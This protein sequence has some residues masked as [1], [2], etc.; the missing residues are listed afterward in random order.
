MKFATHEEFL[1]YNNRDDV[2][3][4]YKRRQMMFVIFLLLFPCTIGG[5]LGFFGMLNEGTPFF[6]NIN[7]Y[8]GSL[9]LSAIGFYGT[10]RCM[11]VIKRT[12]REDEAAAYSR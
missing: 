5:P 6:S 11:K 1:R 3:R 8:L 9:A 7:L 2:K 4:K 10:Y 12:I